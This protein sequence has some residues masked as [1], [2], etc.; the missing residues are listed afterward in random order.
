MRK[1][2]LILFGIIITILFM[3]AIQYQWEFSL[4]IKAPLIMDEKIT[5][6]VSL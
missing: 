3:V 2:Y 4:V 6:Q 5:I 1:K